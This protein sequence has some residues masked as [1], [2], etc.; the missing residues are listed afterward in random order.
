MSGPTQ[1]ETA[2]AAPNAME[3]LSAR[4]ANVPA[5]RGTAVIKSALKILLS[6]S[7][8][9]VASRAAAIEEAHAAL[10]WRDCDGPMGVVT[11]VDDTAG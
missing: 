6:I 7:F 8:S 9:S 2:S 5:P 10:V 3:R 1:A 11:G 4:K